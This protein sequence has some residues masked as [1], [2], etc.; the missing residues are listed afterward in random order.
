M[1]TNRSGPEIDEGSL[2]P[3]EEQALDRLLADYKA[4][5]VYVPG[6][7]GGLARKIAIALIRDGWRK[8]T[9]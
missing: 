4:A 3:E 9:G 8:R 5:T 1:A 7:T 6:Y 2:T